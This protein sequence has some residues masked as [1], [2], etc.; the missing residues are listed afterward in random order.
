MSIKQTQTMVMGRSKVDQYDVEHR[1]VEK[2][3]ESLEKKDP[4]E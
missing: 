1:S 3:L 2:L 4:K